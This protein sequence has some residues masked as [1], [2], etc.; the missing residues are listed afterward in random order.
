MKTSFLFKKTL[1]LFTLILFPIMFFPSPFQMTY[2]SLVT[3]N[4][5]FQNTYLLTI[6]MMIITLMKIQI[7]PTLDYPDNVIH[8]LTCK[9]FIAIQH[10]LIS[11]L[12][13]LILWKTMFHMKRFNHNT[14][15][16][17]W[18]FLLILYQRY[19]LTQVNL[20]ME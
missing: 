15:L 8:P 3:F 17:L 7:L 14:R 18:L 2:L 13:V 5:L 12:S 16:L 9:I 11:L 4:I 1:D 6:I 20:K 19:M 10:K